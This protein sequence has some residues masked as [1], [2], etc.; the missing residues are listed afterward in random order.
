MQEPLPYLTNREAML[1]LALLEEQE[2]F[3]VRSKFAEIAEKG[4]QM[5]IEE[6]RKAMEANGTINLVTPEFV[7]QTWLKVHERIGFNMPVPEYRPNVGK[8]MDAL[9]A[10]LYIDGHSIPDSERK[11][12]EELRDLLGRLS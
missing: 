4:V 7:K 9:E 8:M 12:L 6:L 3:V 11:T 2:F 5:D 10:V 1:Q